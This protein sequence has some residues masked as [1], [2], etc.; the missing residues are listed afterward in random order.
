[1]LFPL[2]PKLKENGRKSTDDDSRAE[3]GDG[4]DDADCRDRHGE[5]SER[6]AGDVPFSRRSG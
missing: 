3:E 2:S 4:G 5:W 6:P 1:M